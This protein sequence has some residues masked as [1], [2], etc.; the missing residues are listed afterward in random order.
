MRHPWANL[1]SIL[2]GNMIMGPSEKGRGHVA[3]RVC[4]VSVDG[5]L[6]ATRDHPLHACHARRPS[7]TRQAEL[8]VG[9]RS[10]VDL[11][12]ATVESNLTPNKARRRRVDQRRFPAL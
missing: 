7:P 4:K 3:K 11:A 12:R 9:Q 5:R 8:E 6:S 2:W 10:R 1:A